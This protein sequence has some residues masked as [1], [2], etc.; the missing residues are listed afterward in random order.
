MLKRE[1]GIIRRG[2]EF[3]KE[4]KLELEKVAWPSRAELLG[5]TSVVIFSVILMAVFLGVVDL[6][7]SKGIEYLIKWQ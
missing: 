5:S 7:F 6:I 2:I 3:L 1:E 4:V